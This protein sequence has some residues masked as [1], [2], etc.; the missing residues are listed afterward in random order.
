MKS[1]TRWK[2]PY[3]RRYPV[4]LATLRRIVARQLTT[5]SLL[6]TYQE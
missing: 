2:R 6:L 3:L 4:S 5:D 1:A